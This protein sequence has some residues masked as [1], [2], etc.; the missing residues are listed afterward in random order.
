V[1]PS[2]LEAANLVLFGTRETNSI[3]GDLAN[4]LPIQLRADAEDHGLVYVYPA[5]G[6]YVLINSGVPW[7][8]Q[9]QE[10]G[11]VFSMQIPALQLMG[12]GDYLLFQQGNDAPLAAG[13][14]DRNWRLTDVQANALRDAGV[15]ELNG[16]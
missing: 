12:M 16:Y 2:D 3:I 11:S 13:R 6:R 5:N 9:R 4:Q 10:P 7:W 14:F 15:V 8:G 1:R